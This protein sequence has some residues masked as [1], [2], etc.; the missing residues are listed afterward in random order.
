[1]KLKSIALAAALAVTGV[2]ASATATNWAAHDLLESSGFV[3]VGVVTFLDTFSFSAGA[4][5]LGS[6]LASGGVSFNSYTL[7]SNPDNVPGN[8]D[9]AFIMGSGTNMGIQSTVIAGGNYFYSVSGTVTSGTGGYVL[10]SAYAAAPIPEPET[11]AL[12]L[13]GLGM[14]GFI[15]ARRRDRR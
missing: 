2:S 15:G 14:I 6:S 3:M 9:D 12:M 13:A 5:T 10:S 11:Y 7:W 1:M 4:G 8:G